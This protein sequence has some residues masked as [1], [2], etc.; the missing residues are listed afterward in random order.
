MA[1][2]Q[3]PSKAALEDACRSRSRRARTSLGH[4][5]DPAREAEAAEAPAPFGKL[6]FIDLAGSERGADTTDN[7]KQTRYGPAASLPC[8]L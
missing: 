1:I 5:N 8:L 2:K 6:S 7:D 3:R 4:P